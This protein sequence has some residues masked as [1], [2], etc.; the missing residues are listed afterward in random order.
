MYEAF[1]I[2]GEAGVK[3]IGELPTGISKALI[4]TITGLIVAIPAYVFY[5]WFSR[6]VDDLTIEM[7]RYAVRLMSVLR[8]SSSAAKGEEA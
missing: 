2:I 5:S 7:E 8:S 6:T 4:T 1:A 3:H